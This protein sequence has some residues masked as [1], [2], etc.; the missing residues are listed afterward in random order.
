MDLKNFLILPHPLTNF[1][2]QKCYQNEP[3]LHG[4]YS[5]DN[6][7]DKVKDG[8]YVINLEEYF[9]TGPHW[10][11]L[12]ALNNHV[13]YFD[14][15]GVEYIR[16]E[17]KKF[18]EGSAIKASTITTNVYRFQVYDL[19]MFKYFCIGFIDF[20]LKGKSLIDFNNLFSTNNFKKWWYDFKLF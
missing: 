6:L 16:K 13:T 9:D 5:R 4:L 1:E 20:I 3:K 15:F 7:P 2:I 11:A 18:F 19:V 10:T 17:V 8:V 12:Y 14:S